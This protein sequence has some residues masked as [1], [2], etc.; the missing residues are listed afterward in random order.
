[1]DGV[2]DWLALSHHSEPDN[3]S[4]VFGFFLDI[5]TFI[6]LFYNIGHALRHVGS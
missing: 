5:Y 3:I 1:M 2:E 4:G 6:I